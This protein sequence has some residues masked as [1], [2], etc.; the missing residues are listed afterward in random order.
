MATP[1]ITRGATLVCPHGGTVNI[2]AANPRV[3]AA[4]QEVSGPN[5]VFLIAGCPRSTPC[6][7]VKWAGGFSARVRIQGQPALPQNAAGICV[8]AAGI[9]AGPVVVAATQ[10]RVKGT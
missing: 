4:G 2:Q 8:D 10:V 6:V 5:N 7:M 1:I 3:R 9:P